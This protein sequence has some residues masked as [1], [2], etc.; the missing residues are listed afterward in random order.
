MV[1]CD[2]VAYVY[3]DSRC[4]HHFVRQSEKERARAKE[5]ER[6]KNN[7][8]VFPLFTKFSKWKKIRENYGTHT[9][10]YQFQYETH[11]CLAMEFELR[12]KIFFFTKM[13]IQLQLNVCVQM[14]SN[15]NNLF[16][17]PFCSLFFSFTLFS[18]PL[19]LIFVPIADFFSFVY[20][21]RYCVCTA[22]N[23][24]NYNNNNFSVFK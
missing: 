18:P 5:K 11:N 19:H 20:S 12:E 22:L 13:L 2:D 1:E 4:E 16:F 14:D 21:F 15:N 17:F 10:Q 6:K 23:H 24:S 8:N 9:Q 3:N 7:N